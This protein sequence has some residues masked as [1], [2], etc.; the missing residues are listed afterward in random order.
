MTKQFCPKCGNKALHRVAVTVDEDGV[1]QLHIDWERLRVTR[2][3]KHSIKM[4]KGGKHDDFEQIVEDQRM[5]QNR[6]A[7]LHQVGISLTACLCTSPVILSDD[8]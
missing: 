3:L 5:P 2:G 4:P 7:R 8:V 1:M 6:M